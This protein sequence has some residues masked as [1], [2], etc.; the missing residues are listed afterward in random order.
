MTDLTLTQWIKLGAGAVNILKENG[1]DISKLKGDI[2]AAIRLAKAVTGLVGSVA[3][4]AAPVEKPA[5]VSAATPAAVQ[6]AA[7]A[8]APAP[9]AAP[10]LTA[11]AAIEH[12]ETHGISAAEQAMFDRASQ[13][14]G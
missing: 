5:E 14:G 13:S 12:V 2:P 8:K 6:P 3:P 7:H 1:A 4:L 9:A 10:R 11:Q